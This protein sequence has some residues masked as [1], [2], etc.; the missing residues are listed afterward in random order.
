MPRLHQGSGS[1]GRPTRHEED[2]PDATDAHRRVL[3]A[4]PRGPRAWL[5][6]LFGYDY[7][8]SH[9]HADGVNYV[10]G[11]A[12]ALR[13]H[14]L[15]ACIDLSEF[16]V[17]DLI[18][19]VTRRRLAMSRRLIVV[20]RP[21]ALR[22]RY[23]REEVEL[24]CRAGG[25]PV[26]INCDE[27][28]NNP[29]AAWLRHLTP[30]NL[31]VPEDT[32]AAPEGPS[33]SVVQALVRG[34]AAR[35]VDSIRLAAFA[36]T[37]VVLAALALAA[38]VFGLQAKK[39]ARDARAGRFAAESALEVSRDPPRALER[40][41]AAVGERTTAATADA[42]VAA[43]HA[44]GPVAA[45]SASLPAGAASIA[46]LAG[47]ETVATESG[48]VL[49]FPANLDR[50]ERIAVFSQASERATAIAGVGGSVVVVGSGSGR[51]AVVDLTHRTVRE[52][53]E[54]RHSAGITSLVWLGGDHL[55]SAAY[56]NQIRMWSIA[57]G[58]VVSAPA[59]AHDS[60]IATKGVM[61]CAFDPVTKTLFTLGAD[62]RI[63]AWHAA[64]PAELRPVASVSLSPSEHVITGVVAGIAWAPR[65]RMVVAGSSKGE[66]FFLCF[67]HQEQ[68]FTRFD[69]AGSD[70][71]PG[72]DREVV[73]L[74]VDGTS[75][76][77]LVA[78]WDGTVTHWSLGGDDGVWPAP[79]QAWR[80]HGAALHGLC[81]A[82]DGR[83][84]LT[85]GDD[86]V[87]RW[88]SEWQ[89]RTFGLRRPLHGLEVAGA[90]SNHGRF[91]VLWNEKNDYLVIETATAAIKGRGRSRAEGRVLRGAVSDNGGW[92]ALGSEFGEVD[93]I[94]LAAGSGPLD[95][96]SL[97]SEV[98]GIALSRDG[99]TLAVG[100]GRGEV[101]TFVT[102][103]PGAEG[104]VVDR[105]A[106]RVVALAFDPSRPILASGA[107]FGGRVL[108]RGIDGG[109]T[110]AE[111]EVEP[112][113][114]VRGLSF[115]PG[116]TLIAIACTG[117][118]VV[119]HD[120]SRAGERVARLPHTNEQPK[121]VAFSLDG[122]RLVTVAD[123]RTIW[124]WDVRAA[125]RE[126]QIP[127]AVLGRTDA[128]AFTP[129]G[130][131]VGADQ[132]GNWGL[133]PG[134]LARWLSET[135]VLR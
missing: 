114:G 128:A 40:A 110:L 108:V 96:I 111:I 45:V 59:A 63:V 88:R 76:E 116:G 49:V 70:G 93:R 61:G 35:R 91:L 65:Q 3:E 77:L 60:G 73:A 75:S 17:G 86:R 62:A 56:D 100:V 37:A 54:Q 89:T 115:Q 134:T 26:L 132:D 58:A 13:R 80:A 10:L 34:Y 84:F 36:L 5:D 32:S 43:T 31:Y 16:H 53:E 30:E 20:C 133:W 69:S 47:G 18:S 82:P 1:A 55:V 21:H 106:G 8:I 124:V 113:N 74:A 6:R 126:W 71:E 117:G 7:F 118:A 67:D 4:S 64:N 122:R 121:A 78:R 51:L 41:V 9:A 135:A 22:S 120:W 27:A 125:S 24:H 119:V 19:Q 66:I 85:A 48:D 50:F 95:M 94:A 104:T 99:D 87:I 72:T 33:E 28:L 57:K 11:L 97:P 38:T 23:V 68:R 90:L 131:I 98:T 123:S 14:R 29:A 12:E 101:T 102:A 112:G 105:H 44:L 39:E 79:V 129:E 107:V 127:G 15:R 52:F 130:D 46:A 2:L 109:A 81:F 103:E 42:L 92:I 83:A 25:V